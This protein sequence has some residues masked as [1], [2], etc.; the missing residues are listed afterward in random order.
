M[1]ASQYH[2][3][4]NPV[5]NAWGNCSSFLKRNIWPYV[6]TIYQF[7]LHLYLCWLS[8]QKKSKSLMKVKEGKKWKRFFLFQNLYF[9]VC[10]YQGTNFKINTLNRHVKASSIQYVKGMKKENKMKYWICILWRNMNELTDSTKRWHY[11][12]RILWFLCVAFF[13]NNGLMQFY[14]IS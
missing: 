2:N 13:K 1:R 14:I 8:L 10:I 6:H 4:P 9:F 3:Y 5:Q 11:R 7:I 12:H